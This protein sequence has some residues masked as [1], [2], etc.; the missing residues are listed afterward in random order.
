[1]PI[2]EFHVVIKPFN[3][4]MLRRLIPTVRHIA[5][6][7]TVIALFDAE[8]SARGPIETHTPGT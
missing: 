1:M 8:G 3:D 6:G 5:D 2:A 4:R 7:D